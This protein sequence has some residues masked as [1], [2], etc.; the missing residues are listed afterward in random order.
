M[1]RQV[2]FFVFTEKKWLKEKQIVFPGFEPLDIFGPLEI[3]FSLSGTYRMTLSTISFH[4]GPVS[5]RLSK[6]F[7][8]GPGG[9]SFDPKNVLNPTIM[10]THSFKNA[11]ELDIIIVPGG[12]GDFLLDNENNF[13]MEHF[14]ASRYERAKYVLSVCTGAT[15]LARAGLLNGKRATTNKSAWDWAT[16]SRHG[17][18]VTWVPNARWVTNEKIWTSSGVAAGMDMMYAFL[19]FYYGS[20]HVNTT[21]NGIEYAPHTDPSWD[22]FAV[23]H[24]VSA[25]SMCDLI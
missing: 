2:L 19:S 12:V 7:T 11:P 16:S 24:K 18:N 23:V 13:E 3:L 8:I 20:E 14:I 10:A 4:Q 17:A 25:F 21:M 9:V 1:H 6:P 15:T 5:A 22:P